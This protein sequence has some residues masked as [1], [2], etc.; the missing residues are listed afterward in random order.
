M[1]VLARLG[2]VELN[3]TFFIM[4]INVGIFYLIVKKF[5]FVPVSSFMEKRKKSIE[6]SINEADKRLKEADEYKN[7]YLEK[8]N[9]AEAE[10]KQIVDK[11]VTSANLKADSIIKEA[12]SE[13]VAI[14]HKAEK[15]IELERK[16][17]LNEA[18]NEISSIAILAASKVLE[19][20]ID[21]NKNSKLVDKFIE[22]VGD[23]K[24]QD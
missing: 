4:L 22:E 18:K 12:K 23:L 11:A 21:E 15:D 13:A 20:E 3:A 2:L 5:L 1:D 24:W 9:N 14:K 7:T 17:I 6:D 19:S 10:S 8:L 16:K